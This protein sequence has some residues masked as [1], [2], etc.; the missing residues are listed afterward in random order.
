MRTHGRYGRS[1]ARR[2][3]ALAGAL[4]L[5][6][7]VLAAPMVAAE[8]IPLQQVVDRSVASAAAAGITQSISVVDRRT[9]ERVAGSGGDRQYISESIVKLFT[10]AYYL[11]QADG[12]PDE[13]M[14]QTLRVMIENSDD[15]IESELWNV[16]I[17]PSMAARYG[18]GHT[19][20]GPK[21]GPHDWGWEL[22]TADDETTFLAGMANDPEVAPLLVDAMAHAAPTAAD[23][24]DQAFGLNALTGDHGSKQGWTDAGPEW[25]EQAQIHSVG[26]TDRYFVA[27]LETA[28][29]ATFEEMTAAST[30]AARAVLAVDIAAPD[31]T[32]T[33]TGPA[34]SL[35]AA[36]TSSG[37]SIGGAPVTSDA[38]GDLATALRH[39]LDAIVAE[40]TAGL[41]EWGR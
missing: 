40:I 33:D 8:Q 39:R 7:G 35:S 41:N 36:P 28:D 14:Q 37:A 4:I 26:W 5:V 16:D 21:T 23:G 19:A 22:I 12:R 38:A 34:E 29:D 10:A 32:A 1:S 17:V 24:T 18:L 30:A 27:I 13:A 6:T 11:A 25:S 3:V 15:D 2:P 20:N 9:G 31:S